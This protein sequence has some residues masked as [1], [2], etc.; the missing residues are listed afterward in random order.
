[1]KP[2]YNKGD[3]IIRNNIEGPGNYVS[4]FDK[5]YET[6]YTIRKVNHYK[7]EFERYTYSLKESHGFQYD[8]KL[9]DKLFDYDIKSNRLKKIKKIYERRKDI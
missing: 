9:I 5:A 8:S 4:I 6:K 1:M 7:H 2:K 3:I